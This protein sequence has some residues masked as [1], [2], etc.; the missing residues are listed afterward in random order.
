MCHATTKN[1]QISDAILTCPVDCIHYVGW[2][3][4]K[5]LESEREGIDI[6][7]KAK[8]V[9]NDHDNVRNGQQVR[10]A[11]FREHFSWIYRLTLTIIEVVTG[12]L[13]VSPLQRGCYAHRRHLKIICLFESPG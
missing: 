8:L 5:K 4:L 1:D 13:T 3:E 6:N 11:A 12:A 9:G 2:G 10:A 7:F